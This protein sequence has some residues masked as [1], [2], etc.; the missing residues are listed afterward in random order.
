MAAGHICILHTCQGR[1]ILAVNGE[2]AQG[3]AGTAYVTEAPSFPFLGCQQACFPL[4]PPPLQQ[5]LLCQLQQGWLVISAQCTFASDA[6]ECTTTPV[7]SGR[8]RHS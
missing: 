4:P 2:V 7:Q 3:I 5:L 8:E 6:Q 1:L